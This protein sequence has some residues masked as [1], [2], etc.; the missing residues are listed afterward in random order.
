M[1]HPKLRLTVRLNVAEMDKNAI[2]TAVRR[3]F[4]L[5]R[6]KENLRRD[7]DAESETGTKTR[8]TETKSVKFPY[9]SAD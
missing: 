1:S 9:K 6:S 4:F 2:E 7:G 3:K 8:D 5:R